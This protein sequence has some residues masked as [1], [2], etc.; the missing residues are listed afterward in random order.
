MRPV[1]ATLALLCCTSI[2]AAVPAPADTPYPGT[3]KLHVDATDLD[4]RVFRVHEEIPAAP[5]ATEPLAETSK[6][7]SRECRLS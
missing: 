1:V 3:L 6:R 7:W 5:G 2:Y 4:H